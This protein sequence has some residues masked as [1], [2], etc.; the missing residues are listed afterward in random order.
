MVYDVFFLLNGS[1]SGRLRRGIVDR[2]VNVLAV[3]HEEAVG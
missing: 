1:G 2:F 3:S